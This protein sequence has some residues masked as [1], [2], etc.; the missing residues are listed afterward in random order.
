MAEKSRVI[1]GVCRC[2]V[3]G[4]RA[5][6]VVPMVVNNVCGGGCCMVLSVAELKTV[7]E[8]FLR[9]GGVILKSID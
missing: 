6:E 9:V 3:Y 5:C 2:C 4:T 8:K 7:V 1:V